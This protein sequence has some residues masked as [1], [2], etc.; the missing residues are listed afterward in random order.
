LFTVAHTRLV[1]LEASRNSAVSS[2]HTDSRAL[3][4]QKG[5]DET[6]FMRVLATQTEILYQHPWDISPVNL[7]FMKQE[8]KYSVFFLS[9]CVC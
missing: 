8:E 5:L 7:M 3:E 2:T 6:Q 4:L 9:L 1:S